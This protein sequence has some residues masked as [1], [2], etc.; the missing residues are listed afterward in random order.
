MD[1]QPTI[2]MHFSE[3]FKVSR[4]LQAMFEDAISGTRSLEE[5]MRRTAEFVG[6]ITELPC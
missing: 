3:Y 4:L 5:I 2:S 6:V 1:N